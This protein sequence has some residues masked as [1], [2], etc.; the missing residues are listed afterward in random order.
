M[1]MCL[2]VALAAVSLFA[3]NL[4]AR[5]LTVVTFGGASG[6]A[7][8][9]VYVKPFSAKEGT[10][11]H[12]DAW[13]GEMAR[14]RAQIDSG[15]VTWDVLTAQ[16]TD[17]MTGCEEG[18][19][20]KI[21]WS[22][23]SNVADLAPDSMTECGLLGLANAVVLSYDGARLNDGPK[24]WADFWDTT[25]YPGKRGLRYSAYETLEVALLADG[26]PSQDVYKVLSTEA[27]VKRAFDKLEVL[28]PDIIWWRSGN[29]AIQRLASGEV[30]MTSVWN[31]RPALVNKTD[32]RD[33]R[34]VW[35]AGGVF[36]N[37]GYGIV[38]G[39]QNLDAAYKLL[40]YMAMPEPEA[41][42][43]KIM[44][45]G[46]PNVKSYDLVDK[47]LLA[48]LASAPENKKYLTP[49]DNEFWMNNMEALTAR[50]TAWAGTN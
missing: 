37:D 28:K 29:E 6:Q 27:G 39:T 15:T 35:Q 49:V 11:Y 5:D 20:E 17:F 8:E 13:T 18:L 25:K 7:V 43:Y 31:A 16:A 45:Y 50:F 44:P 26:V 12:M 22:R 14:V 19:F 24:S 4:H 3:T 9:D 36:E 48:D 1:R 46:G 30:A 10:A 23:F 41:E 38:K 33:L 40:H 42:F 2:G 34:V 32:K 47:S 21:D